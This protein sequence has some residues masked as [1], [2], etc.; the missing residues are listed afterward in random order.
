[1]RSQTGQVGLHLRAAHR[2][3]VTQALEAD[4]GATPVQVRLLRAQASCSMR[5]RSRN[6]IQ[7]PNGLTACKG[8]RSTGSAGLSAARSEAKRTTAG[9]MAGLHLRAPQTVRAFVTSAA[10]DGKFSTV[11]INSQEDIKA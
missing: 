11:W 8:G 1:V 4:E 3:G 9:S 6:W 2:C 10:F 7:Q 5:M